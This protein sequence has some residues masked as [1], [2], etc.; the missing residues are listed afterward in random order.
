MDVTFVGVF[1]DKAILIS[2]KKPTDEEKEDH[3]VS[4]VAMK[5]VPLKDWTR[6]LELADKQGDLENG[7]KIQSPIAIHSPFFDTNPT[8]ETQSFLDAVQHKK[9]TLNRFPGQ[10][11]K[12]ES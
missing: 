10:R 8:S 9:G 4:S 1:Q 12:G 3:F 6:Q 7:R 2:A 11:S 5:Y